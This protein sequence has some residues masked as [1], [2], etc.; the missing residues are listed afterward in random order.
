MNGVVVVVVV[1]GTF[2]HN[3]YRTKKKEIEMRMMIIM[4]IRSRTGKISQ[5]VQLIYLRSKIQMVRNA[6][7]D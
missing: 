1:I 3:E 7:L 5:K 4:M 2:G 6:R